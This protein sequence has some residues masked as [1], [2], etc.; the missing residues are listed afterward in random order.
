MRRSISDRCRSQI[1]VENCDFCPVRE[2]Q[3]EYC[4]NVWCGKTRM[5]WLPDGEKTEDTFIRFDR[6]H[7]L[8]GWTDRRTP[9]DGVG[10]AYAS[11]A[12][13]K[14]VERLWI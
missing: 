1:L 12:R 2:S 8:D 9:H 3:S 13:Q 14:N 11:I 4:Q 6:I 5:M 10:R 7:E